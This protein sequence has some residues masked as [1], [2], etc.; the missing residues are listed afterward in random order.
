MGQACFSS[1]LI[2]Y[3]ERVSTKAPPTPCPAQKVLGKAVGKTLLSGPALGS[4]QGNLA[5][6]NRLQPALTSQ[7]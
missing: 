3:N 6:P 5:S 1:P 4:G 7:G 2:R